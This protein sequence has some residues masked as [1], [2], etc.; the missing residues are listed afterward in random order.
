MTPQEIRARLTVPWRHGEFVDLAGVECDA[1]LDLS[2]CTL[3][4]VDFSGAR[5]AQGIDA[6]GARFDGICWFRGAT[7]GG[8]AHFGG[9]LFM[10]DARFE[11][12]RFDRAADFSGA[13]FR[14]IGRFDNTRFDAGA[15]FSA[16]V[17]Y[18]NVSLQAVSAAGPVTFRGG[19]WLGGLWCQGARL[20]AETDLGETQVHGRLWL[21][22]ARRGNSALG[23]GDFGMSFGYTYV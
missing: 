7:F 23:S 12:S 6:R 1:P 10:N 3:T 14:G 11:N 5:F 15:D 8:P 22:D 4:G 18:G 19:E 21:R 13:E 2:G 17:S 20:P 9:A 16:T